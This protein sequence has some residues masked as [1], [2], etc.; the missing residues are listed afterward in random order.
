MQLPSTS[1]S[2][3]PVSAEAPTEL[4]EPVAEER[5]NLEH[6]SNCS[7]STDPPA[8]RSRPRSTRPLPF[9]I[10]Q[11]KGEIATFG[12]EMQRILCLTTLPRGTSL[13]ARG[14]V[15]FGPTGPR[16][17]GVPSERL[18][19]IADGEVPRNLRKDGFSLN[20]SKGRRAAGS[21]WQ[22][23]SVRVAS[24]LLAA[25]VLLITVGLSPAS[26]QES[27]TPSR[28]TDAASVP[29]PHVAPGQQGYWLVGSDG[30]VF[31][32]GAASFFGSMGGKS[33]NEPI[34]GMADT[35]G[36]GGYW[37]VA[38]D[39]GVFAFGNAGF[40]GSIPA[41]GLSPVDSPILPR[42]NAPIV[43]IVPSHDGRGYLLVAA[44][45][46]VFAFGDAQFEGSCPGIGGC[47][48]GTGI[49]DVMTDGSGN[50]YWV[51]SYN[52]DVRAFGDAVNY[53]EPAS[54]LP[55]ASIVRSGVGTPS[56]S[57]YWILFSD[58][59]IYSYGNAT[60]FGGPFGQI[61]FSHPAEAIFATSDGDGYWVTTA[62]GA[63]YAFGD[64]T[65]DGG[66]SATHL[67][68]SIVAATGF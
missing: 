61:Q 65:Y 13:R 43:G 14:S 42:L 48:G 22:R 54:F 5:E 6:E 52:G 64:A 45:G 68:G 2:G 11:V 26:A 19:T 32:F 63:V 7:P 56:G 47:F 40:Y 25:A 4:N 12:D 23:M 50:G 34:V 55:Y 53:G 59:E 3:R 37:L 8:E 28:G 36:G 66:M 27:A 41:L 31:S 15:S 44:D 39:G 62:N 49:A 33:L 18:E 17:G 46:G 20:R 67:N 9:C 60:Y 29:T 21:S 10:E 35:P 30:G 16:S 24:G 57:G 38:S 1:S 58:G 51:V